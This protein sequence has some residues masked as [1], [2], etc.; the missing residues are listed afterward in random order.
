M[1]RRRGR[2][3]KPYIAPPTHGEPSNESGPWVI[4]WSRGRQ[5][6]FR[7]PSDYPRRAIVH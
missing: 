4:V 3:G 5:L 7:Q 2:Y 6:R 1:G